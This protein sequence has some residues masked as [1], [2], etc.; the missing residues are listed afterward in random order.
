MVATATTV[1]ARPDV[2]SFDWAHLRK[3]IQVTLLWQAGGF[4]QVTYVEHDREPDPQYVT[5][6]ITGWVPDDTLTDARRRHFF[7][8]GFHGQSEDRWTV[9]TDNH[10]FSL[11]W[12]PLTDLPAT[13]A[14]HSVVI[15][16]QDHW[17]RFLDA[18]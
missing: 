17:L 6:C 1:Y 2:A 8:L 4:S 9:Y 7:H 11:F 15:P 10:H 16:P 12:A 14:R 5:Y 13:L 3:G 18:L